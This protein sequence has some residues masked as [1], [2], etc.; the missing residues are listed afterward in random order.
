VA[1]PPPKIHFQVYEIS[2][3]WWN[4][5]L[6]KNK[7]SESDKLNSGNSEFVEFYIWHFNFSCE[8]ETYEHISK[9]T[10]IVGIQGILNG[11]RLSTV[12]L[13][14]KVAR[15]VKRSIIFSI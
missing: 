12:D 9:M 6:Y 2:K 8:L 13:L 11:G 7:K 15:F 10:M 1:Y 14:N 5:F 3:I 4:L